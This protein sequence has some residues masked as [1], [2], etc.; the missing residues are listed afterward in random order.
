MFS[1]T[2]EMFEEDIPKIIEHIETNKL[3]TNVHLIVPMYGGLT[4]ANK[5]RNIQGYKISLVKMSVY[6]EKDVKASWI[7]ENGISVDE[8]LIIIDDLW[9]SGCTFKETMDLVRKSFPNNRISAIAL[10]GNKFCPSWLWYVN[11]KP[12]EWIKYSTWE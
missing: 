4:I 7:H 5:L 12:P 9:D 6:A 1:Y 3:R 11:E 8:E 2:H 10:H